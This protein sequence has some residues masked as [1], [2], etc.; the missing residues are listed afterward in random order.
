MTSSSPASLVSSRSGR[1]PKPMTP[2]RGQA[3][4][5]PVAGKVLAPAAGPRS[6]RPNPSSARIWP[7]PVRHGPALTVVSEGLIAGGL[8]RPFWL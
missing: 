2:A 6:S 4:I 1:A 7:T 5:A 8:T 3:G